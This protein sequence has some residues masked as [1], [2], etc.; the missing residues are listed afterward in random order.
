MEQILNNVLYYDKS[1]LYQY[2]KEF[3]DE[4]LWQYFHIIVDLHTQW[5][6]YVIKQRKSFNSKIQSI[7]TKGTY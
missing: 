5:N 3:S 6:E 2:E 1:K 4:L 7:K